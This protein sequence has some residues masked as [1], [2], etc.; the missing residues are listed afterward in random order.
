MKRRAFQRVGP[1]E[2][3]TRPSI[4]PVLLLRLKGNLDLVIAARRRGSHRGSDAVGMPSNTGPLGAARQND[5]GNASPSQVLLVADATV[6][7][8]QQ[9][10][11]RIL[12]R[13]QERAV[14]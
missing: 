3:R 13:G 7:R 2:N 8:E 11:P 12:C 10:E 5:N 9:F 4:E 14:A 1:L 6:G